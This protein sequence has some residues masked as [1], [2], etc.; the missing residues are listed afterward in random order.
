M[1]RIKADPEEKAR[2]QAYH[3]FLMDLPLE[4]RTE[5]RDVIVKHVTR[6]DWAVKALEENLGP[7][8]VGKL[9]SGTGSPS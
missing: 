9:K 2:A 7:I 5:V 4:V 6:M 1:P 3:A 8:L